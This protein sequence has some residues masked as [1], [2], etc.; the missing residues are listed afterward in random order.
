MIDLYS[1]LLKLYPPDYRAV[2]E[3]EML[4]VFRDRAQER[5]RKWLPVSV[6]LLSLE[7]LGILEGAAVEWAARFRS[8]DYLAGRAETAQ[9][10]RDAVPAEIIEAEREL[11]RTLRGMVYAIA[12]HRFHQA[13]AY[14]DEERA[15]RDRLRQLRERHGLHRLEGPGPVTAN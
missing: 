3:S 7:I 13:R 14:S 10:D 9:H 11:D 5:R 15:A 6:A 1:W 2:F 4:A 12:H 8:T